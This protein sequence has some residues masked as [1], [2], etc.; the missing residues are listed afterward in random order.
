MFLFVL[1]SLLL[2]LYRYFC[3]ILESIVVC[4]HC[5][6]HLLNFWWTVFMEM[7]LNKKRKSVLVLCV[8][9][10]GAKGFCGCW[11]IFIC[12]ISCIY[13]YIYI[14]LWF[15]LCH[16]RTC[17]VF[18]WWLGNMWSTLRRKKS[19]SSPNKRGWPDSHQ[20]SSNLICQHFWLAHF[21]WQTATFLLKPTL[22]LSSSTCF[23]HVHFGLPF[24]LWPSTSKSNALSRHERP[25]SSTHDHANKHFYSQLI[26]GFI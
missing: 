20:P 7:G 10:V 14:Y 21:D 24:F 8:F 6:E 5:P 2:C 4:F 15:A 17:K 19:G 25:L 13:I 18:C 3:H 26:H 16:V 9:S 22:T 12:C 23:F 11:V 1:F